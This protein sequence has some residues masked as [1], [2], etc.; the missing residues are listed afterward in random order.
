MA[1]RILDKRLQENVRHCRIERVGMD[2]ELDPQ[3]LSKPRLLN[4]Q[5]LF[6]E[7]EFLLQRNFLRPDALE[8]QPEQVAEL[9]EHRIGRFSIAV[10]QRRDR[11]QRVE[12][13]V[14]VQLALERLQARLREPRLELRGCELALPALPCGNRSR[15]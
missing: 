15:D 10:H 12:E 2:V 8:R 4:L 11:M 14:R 5:V 7:V 13:E 9:R 1:N 3:A 6:Q